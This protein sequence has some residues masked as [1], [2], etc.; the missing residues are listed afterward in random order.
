M[1]IQQH[2]KPAMGAAFAVAIL[3][4]F[5]VGIFAAVSLINIVVKGGRDAAWIGFGG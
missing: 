5:A 1:I 3:F 2:R 4:W